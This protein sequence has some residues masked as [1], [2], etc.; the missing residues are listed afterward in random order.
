MKA[1]IVIVEDDRE[2]CQELGEILEGEGYLVRAAC[3][4]PDGL[5]L[6]EKHGCDLLLLDLKLPG[7]TGEEILGRLS[8][9]RVK[10]KVLVLTAR[11][12]NGDS[13]KDSLRQQRGGELVQDIV[14]KPFDIPVLLE[15][16]RS[17][18]G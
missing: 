10:P 3:N 18:I 17:L 14:S 15:K 7:I 1:E 6:I 9:G 2:M 16:I 8:A 5:A 13:A 11:I 12:L 4:G